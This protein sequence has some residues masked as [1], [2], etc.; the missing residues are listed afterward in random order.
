MGNTLKTI[1][2]LKII[3][4]RIKLA[5]ELRKMTQ[6][7]LAGLIGKSRVTIWKIETGQGIVPV[8]VLVDIMDALDVAEFDILSFSLKA[9][10]ETYTFKNE[11]K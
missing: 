5:R 2:R 8:N 11:K 9:D 7:Q 4:E 10:G 6:E 3:G 1:N